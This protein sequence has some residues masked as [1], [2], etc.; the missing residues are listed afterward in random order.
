MIDQPARHPITLKRI[1]RNLEAMPR[2]EVTHDVAYHEDLQ[3]DVY[4]PATSSAAPVVV[5]VAGYRDVGVPLTLG[6]NFREMEFNV[7]LAQLIAV[8][9]M[10]AITYST[11]SP[12]VDAGRVADFIARSGAELRVDANRIGIWSS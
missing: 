12:A 8:S 3:L 7:S 10:A 9:G 4:H 5:I 11:S 2:V 1:I 6:C